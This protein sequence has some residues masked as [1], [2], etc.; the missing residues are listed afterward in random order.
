MIIKKP[1][2]REK[3]QKGG[4]LNAEWT[5]N[6]IEEKEWK[7]KEEADKKNDWKKK[8]GRILGQ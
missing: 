8:K 3:A 1:T 6:V 5:V 2:N 7:E 4:E